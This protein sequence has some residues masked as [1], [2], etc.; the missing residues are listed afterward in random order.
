MSYWEKNEEFSKRLLDFAVRIIKLC[1]AL[2]NS[3]LAVHLSKQLVRSGTS[4]G[5]NY[6][7]ARGAESKADFIH[8]ITISLKEIRE[9]LYWLRIIQSSEALKP[10]RLDPIIQEADEIYSILV[11]S[12]KTSKE[13][14]E[15]S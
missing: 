1:G 11:S 5:A 3:Y 15:D 8:K 13:N 12:V 6:E 7:E 2:P 9:T 14:S 4:V 10:E